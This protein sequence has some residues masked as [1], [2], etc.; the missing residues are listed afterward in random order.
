MPYDVQGIY[1]VILAKN[2]T[3]LRSAEARSG[4]CGRRS[5]GREPLRRLRP[6]L[7]PV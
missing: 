2:Y 6:V 5:G 1:S 4:G 7:R 3:L